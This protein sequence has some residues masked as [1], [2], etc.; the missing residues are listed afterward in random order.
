MRLTTRGRYAVTAMLD[1]ALQ[2][3]GGAV[4]LADIAGRHHLSISYLEQ[5]LARLRRE[6]LV[7]SV[8]GPGGGYRLGRD[9]ASIRVGDI[10]D[11]IDET[12]DATRCGGRMN[13]APGRGRCLSHGLWDAL[14]GEIRSFLDEMTLAR[15]AGQPHETLN[16]CRDRSRVEVPAPRP[17]MVA[18]RSVT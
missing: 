2:Q 3:A 8:R 5:L 4:T 7:E 16:E 12:V 15:L 14:N 1:I 13:C 11:A 17:P 18:G 9:A 6:G 10:I